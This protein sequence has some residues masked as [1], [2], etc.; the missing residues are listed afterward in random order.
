MPSPPAPGRPD[1]EGTT[2][3]GWV[4]TGTGADRR[5][6]VVA[7]PGAKA[8]R[9][10]R[11]LL[12]AARVVFARHGYLDTTVDHIVA[13][14]GLA[15]G[16]LYTYFE[17]KVDLF[18]HLA[19]IIDEQVEHDVV[20]FPRRGTS[21]PIVNLEISNRNYLAVVQ[22]NADLYR[23]V[24]QVAAYDDEVRKARL[25]SRQRHVARVASTIRRWQARGLADPDVDAGTTAAALVSM[26]SG[27]AQW[28]YVGGDSADEDQA[29]ATLTTIWI[30]ACGLDIS[31]EGPA[32]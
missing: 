1:G 28:L 31:R 11:R 5:A 20:S 6:A 3:G 21:D 15:R 13:E 25:R 17:S 29:V 4:P 10:R 14:A 23:L 24:D 27:S 2:R 9:T 7:S 16:S 30:K 22:A 32:S 18:R 26:L 19:A 12:D 8:T